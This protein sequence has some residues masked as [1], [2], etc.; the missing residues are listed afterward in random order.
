MPTVLTDLDQATPDWLTMI[1]QREGVLD[2]GQVVAVTQEEVASSSQVA[3][4]T[5]MYT[6]DVS[7]AAPTHLLLKI[8]D[9]NL[10]RMMPQRN[11]REVQ[12]YH[13]VAPLVADLPV[14]HCYDAA[15]QRAEVDRFHLLLADPSATTHRSY[16]Y[17]A[18]PPTRA[19]SERI[20][21]ALAQVHARCW[22]DR[23]VRAAFDEHQ[24]A[25][26]H[27]G[28][29]TEGFVHWIDDT[30]PRF[31]DDVGE[32]VSHTRGALYRHIGKH[33][34]SRLLE[35]QAHGQNLTLTQGDVHLGNFLYPCDPT[36][37]H[38]YIIDW[39]RAAPAMGASDL[40][41]M[42]ALYWFPAV[43]AQ[44]EH[45]LLERYHQRLGEYGVTGYG[46]AD[47]WDDYRLS[48]LKELC[49]PIWGWSVG[50]NTLIWWNHLERIT[51]AIEDLR[52]IDAL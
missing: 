11:V 38:L 28:L 29:V 34:P 45:A 12:F 17:S 3:H 2:R 50:Q 40:A 47:V 51:H 49:E 52:C 4:L 20:I 7:V 31:L 48:V 18:V 32:R 24:A 30:L 46:W 14:V 19:Q 13:V 23:R 8:A 10:E 1:L 27:T 26:R 25:E 37:D 5:L 43:R 36:V 21:D 44:W 16:R 9:P 41:Y 39:K 22:D 15:Y 33:L 35:R 6:P 42:M